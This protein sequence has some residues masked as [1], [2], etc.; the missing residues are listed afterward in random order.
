MARSW[1]FR[2]LSS[3]NHHTFVLQIICVQNITAL[4]SLRVLHWERIYEI[5]NVPLLKYVKTL[6]PNASKIH[7]P[8]TVPS[9]DFWINLTLSF[10][11]YH[12]HSV[13]TESF[14]AITCKIPHVFSSIIIILESV[15]SLPI[16]VCKCCFFV[17]FLPDQCG[18]ETLCLLLDLFYNLSASCCVAHPTLET[19]RVF[20]GQ[21]HSWSRFWSSL[22][23]PLTSLSVF[24]LWNYIE[25]HFTPL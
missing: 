2:W 20:I 1:N 8:I 18:W 4:S 12:L 17:H 10:T 14:Y 6:A 16:C 23:T 3:L 15:N 19:E 7:V 9:L 25:R 22:G 24:P 21:D 13:S 11:L 5:Q